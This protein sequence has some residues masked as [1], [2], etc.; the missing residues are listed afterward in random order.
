[1][2]WRNSKFQYLYFVLGECH[3]AIEAH[4]RCCEELE[5]REMAEASNRGPFTADAMGRNLKSCIDQLHRDIDFLR[6]CKARLE[7]H[8]GYVPTQD[9]YQS[10]QRLEWKLKLKR[11][12][13]DYMLSQ[14]FVPHDQMAVI[15]K[16]PDAGELIEHWQLCKPAHQR[17]LSL[18]FRRL[19]P[20][21]FEWKD[22]LLLENK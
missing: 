10:N 20:V 13:E 6:E 2:Y 8:L 3:T 22:Q 5:D 15:R 17:P 16:H 7:A 1:M 9:D 21:G 12:V 11:R 14:G 18:L 4:R 19:D